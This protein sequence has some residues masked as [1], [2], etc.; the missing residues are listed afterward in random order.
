MARN[1][2]GFRLTCQRLSEIWWVTEDAV[3]YLN[4]MIV[5]YGAFLNRMIVVFGAFRNRMIVVCGAF[6]ILIS[7]AVAFFVLVCARDAGRIYVYI[8]CF[9]GAFWND[10]CDVSCDCGHSLFPGGRIE[11]FSGLRCCIRVNFDTINVRTR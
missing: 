3:K 4:R 8:C 10:C 6:V 11:I 7:F 9:V 2:P 1:G 5:I